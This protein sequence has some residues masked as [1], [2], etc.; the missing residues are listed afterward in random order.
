MARVTEKMTHE[1]GGMVF[2]PEAST[3]DSNADTDFDIDIGSVYSY[4]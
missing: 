1:A 4:Q 2:M 3:M